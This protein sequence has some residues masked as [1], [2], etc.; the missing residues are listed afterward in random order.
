MQW[1]NPKIWRGIFSALFAFGILWAAFGRSPSGTNQQP[2][3]DLNALRSWLQERDRFGPGLERRLRYEWQQR[4]LKSRQARERE[5]PLTAAPGDE[6]HPSWSPDGRFIAFST[7]SEDTN[8]NGRLDEKDGKG[9][10]FRIWLMNP[11]GS[12]ARPAIPESDI[13]PNLPKGDELYPAWFSN[14]GAIAFV[15]KG[16]DGSYICI[17]NLSTS[18]VKVIQL[19]DKLEGVGRVSVG[20]SG[21]EIVFEQNGQIFLLRMIDLSDPSKN[22]VKQLTSE[23]INR[24]PVYLPDGR[25]LYESNLDPTTGQP[26]T[27]FHIWIMDEEGQ[28][29]RPITRGNQNDTDPAPIYPNTELRRRGFLVAFARGDVGNRDIFISDQNGTV[30]RQVSPIGNQTDEY[31]PTVEPFPALPNTSERIAFVTTRKGNEDIWSISSIDI[32][33]PMLS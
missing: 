23:G 33:P 21:T 16:S 31:Q 13:P 12:N 20:P 25:I 9:Q 14:S 24:N 32:S 5:V 28:N 17:A 15:M 3:Y 29:P 27:N 11:D 7:N 6:R 1:K 26:G 19:T 22:Q 18:P 2:N 30:V 4:A 10:R 8:R